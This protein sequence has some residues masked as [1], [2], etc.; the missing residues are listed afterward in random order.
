MLMLFLP[1]L[2]LQAVVFLLPAFL[3]RA[4][5][6]AIAAQLSL[7]KIMTVVL[8]LLLVADTILF[9]GAVSRSQR[10]HLTLA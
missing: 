10:S 1:L 8:G 4:T 3:P 5:V 2:S 9:L 6:S 7:T